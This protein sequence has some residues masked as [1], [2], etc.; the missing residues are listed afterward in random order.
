MNF[1]YMVLLLALGVIAVLFFACSSPLPEYEVSSPT[2]ALHDPLFAEDLVKIVHGSADVS[3]A[4]QITTDTLGL[5]ATVVTIKTDDGKELFVNCTYTVVSPLIESMTLELGSDAPDAVEWLDTDT[6]TSLYGI[7]DPESFYVLEYESAPDLS[8][9]GT[10]TVNL[11]VGTAVLP[12]TITVTDT[13]APVGEPV[14]L[15]ITNDS[16]APSASDFVTN[17]IDESAVSVSFAETYDFSY[18]HSFPVTVILADSSGNTTS[19]TATADCRVDTEYPVISVDGDLYVTVGN[20]VSYKS[21]LT[22][23]DNA[24]DPTVTIDNSAVDLHTKGQYEIIYTATDAAGNSTSVSRRL[25]VVEELPPEEADV[26][27]LAEKVYY[28][29]ILTREGMTKYEIAYAIYDWC[30]HKILFD[31]RGTDRTLGPIKLAYDGFTTLKGDCYTY[32]ITAKYLFD[33]AGIPTVEVQR[34]RYEG[35]SFHFWLLVDIGD[36]W[37][38]FDATSRSTGRGTD[39][40]MLTDAELAAF[41]TRFNVPH[42]FRFDHSAYPE[43]ATDSYFD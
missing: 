21:G 35:E 4:T 9:A 11:V 40:F 3:T 29:K 38:H 8:T 19:V 22:A 26:I 24:G 37:Y 5:N 16:G 32:M 10:H 34:L 6:L 7:R 17:V 39:T 23:S 20:A 14:S 13:V 42:Y 41:C 36:G 2:I 15:V 1:R 30:Y 43:R 27:A 31:L 18:P 12:V 33:I 28:E 25:F